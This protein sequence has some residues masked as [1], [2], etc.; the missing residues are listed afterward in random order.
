MTSNGKFSAATIEVLAKRAAFHCSNPDCVVLTTGPTASDVGS[1]NIGEAAHIHG[2]TEESARYSPL[3]SPSERADITNGI[4][5]CRNCHKEIDNDPVRFPAELLFLWRRE[6][7]L[8]VTERLG[9]KGELIREK[10]RSH[11]LEPFKTA[12]YLAQQI[13]LDRPPHWEYK[14]TAELL[15]SELGEVH[16]KWQQLKRRLYVR[17]SALLPPDS[18]GSWH[19]A[20]FD[21]LAEAVD[22]LGRL[23]STEFPRAWGESGPPASDTEI[24]HVCRLFVSIAVNFLHWEEEVRFCR[25]PEEFHEYQ[26][27]LEGAA[28]AQIEEMMRAPSELSKIFEADDPAHVHN[29]VLVLRLPEKLRDLVAVLDR[30]YRAY[31]SRARYA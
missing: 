16:A 1:V 28:G 24:L 12:S 23:I 6:H 11:R 18:I 26:A 22:A 13:V 10:L 2:R 9:H 14:L 27:L 20:K 5:L 7:E 25:L 3:V 4:W 17:R 15:R 8:A 31:L 29:I 21:D 19:R 30:C